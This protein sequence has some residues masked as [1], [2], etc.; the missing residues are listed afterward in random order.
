MVDERKQLQ[1]EL[2]EA[3]D[4][5]D[6]VVAEWEKRLNAYVD[7]ALGDNQKN[8]ANAEI[9]AGM[10]HSAQPASNS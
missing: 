8:N 10:I 5:A 4:D 6:T 9:P 7:Q 3:L 1:R 2:Y